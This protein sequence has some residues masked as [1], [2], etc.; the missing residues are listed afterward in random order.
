MKNDPDNAGRYV[1][2]GAEEPL[3]HYADAFGRDYKACH[4]GR[5]ID[6]YIFGHYHTPGTVEIPSGGQMHILGCWVDGGEY[7]VFE[8]GCLSIIS[9]VRPDV[10]GQ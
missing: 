1:F 8:D 5:G 10:S 9:A 7:A 4:G 6:Y 2:R 3:Y